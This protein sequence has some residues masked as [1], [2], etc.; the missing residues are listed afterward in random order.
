VASRTKDFNSVDTDPDFNILE[1]LLGNDFDYLSTTGIITEHTQDLALVHTPNS[2]RATI[3][4][5]NFYPNK[6]WFTGMRFFAVN[7]SPDSTKEDLSVTDP[8]L[9]EMLFSGVVPELRS[10][11]VKVMHVTRSVGIRSKIAVAPTTEGVDAVGV[12][13]GKA[14]N[15]VKFVT[16]MLLGERVDVVAYDPDPIIFLQNA[17]GVSFKTVD[18]SETTLKITVPSH[19]FDA[20]VGGGGL[21]A[22]LAARLTKTR[23]TIEPSS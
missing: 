22:A 15:R 16:S 12:F 3:A 7:I 18:D 4:A 5:S 21:N 1:S 17:L 8:K 13:V 20:A 10:G 6:K 19:Q 23:F 14:A 2:Q 9:V 11:L